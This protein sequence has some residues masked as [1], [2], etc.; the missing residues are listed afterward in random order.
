MTHVRRRAPSVAA[1][2]LPF[3]LLLGGPAGAQE[4]AERADV[5]AAERLWSD[6]WTNGDKDT[7]RHL[8]AEE[9][10]WTYITGRVI[11]KDEAI[12]ALD[13]FVVTESSK[14]IHLY[15]DTAVVY[16]IA[17]LTFRGRPITERFVRVWVKSEG[18][19][20]AVLFQATEIS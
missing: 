18:R 16:G 15:G 10:T 7:Y 17:R 6:A 9:F 2:T 4:Q 13:P 3:A 11:G 19:L 8:L 20:R 5:E 12:E 14:T 1:W